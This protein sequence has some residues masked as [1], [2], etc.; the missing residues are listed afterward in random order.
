MDRVESRILQHKVDF[1]AVIE[2]SMANPN[3]D[4][5]LGNRPR[6]DY[7]DFGEISAECLKRKIR[8]RLQDEGEKILIQSPE[9]AGFDGK[10]SIKERVEAVRAVLAGEEKR[11]S[12]EVKDEEIRRRILEEY[13][14]VRAFGATLAYS[15]NKKGDEGGNVSIGIRG[16]VTIRQARSADP[17]RIRE[18]GI[19]KSVNGE[20]AENKR[21][22]KTE[23]KDSSTMGKRWFVEF[24]IYKVCGSINAYL[25]D[26]TGFSEKDEEKIKEALKTIFVNDASSAR[27]EGSM[28]LL[29]LYWWDHKTKL[30]EYSSRQVHDSVKIV[31]REGTDF[32]RSSADYE[33][34]VDESYQTAEN[35]LPYKEICNELQ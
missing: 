13:L 22:E 28:S 7:E 21:G 5:S 2:V 19:T 12:S 16:P 6:T 3:G 26:L 10:G 9:R 15:G 17:V 8:N 32:P 33:I 31:R 34:S 29:K 30:G 23:G 14:D 4:P 18:M 20:P 25:S 11:K 35:R 24:G 1:V 27:P